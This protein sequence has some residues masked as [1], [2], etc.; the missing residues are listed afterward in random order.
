MLI[1]AKI[2]QLNPTGDATRLIQPYGEVHI[3]RQEKLPAQ[4]VQEKPEAV[5]RRA[6]EVPGES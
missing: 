6:Q 4:V 3:D 1:I 2:L 5:D